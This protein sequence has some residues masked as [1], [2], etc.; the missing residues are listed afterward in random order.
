MRTVEQIRALSK[1]GASHASRRRRRK[2]TVVGARGRYPGET[3]SWP[4]PRVPLTHPALLLPP[5]RNCS[6]CHSFLSSRAQQRGRQ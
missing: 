5:L 4:P 2:R 1:S 3:D 6:L